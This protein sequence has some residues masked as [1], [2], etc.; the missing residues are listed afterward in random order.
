MLEQ[1]LDKIRQYLYQH[2]LSSVQ[3]LVGHTNSSL[4]TIRRDLEKLETEGVVIRTH[5]GAKL[6][7]SSGVEVGFRQ[8]E[9]REVSYKRAIA[10]A[11][12]KHLQP[13]SSIFLDSS[14]TALQLARRLRLHPIRLNL[15]TN[16]FAAAQELFGVPEVQL[17]F[18]GGHIR[19]ENLATVGMYAEETLDRL[20]FDQLFMSA[21]AIHQDHGFTTFDTLEAAINRK[22]LNRATKRFMLSDFTK[23]GR[24]APHHIA[25]LSVVQH[26]ITDSRLS[27][28]WA[29]H[30]H[31]AGV[32][33]EQT[34]QSITLEPAQSITLEPHH[35]TISHNETQVSRLQEDL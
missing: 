35:P 34:A 17:L 13:D 25:A 31:K 27:S 10:E 11:A 29:E 5:G 15:T 14:T 32:H 12:Y 23:F 21:N 28:T 8:R 2:G 22:M 1:R 7:D 19:T 18:V 26:I 4:A 3:T 33:L 30:L 16:S 20:W 6:A 24:I 9:H